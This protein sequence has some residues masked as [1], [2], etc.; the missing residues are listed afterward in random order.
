[1]VVGSKAGAPGHTSGRLSLKASDIPSVFQPA[2]VLLSYPPIISGVLVIDFPLSEA[3][4]RSE[5]PSGL[6]VLRRRLERRK[7]N[8][9]WQT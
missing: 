2:C 1:M 3:L 4:E 8:L 7:Y 9:R 5:Y 6:L